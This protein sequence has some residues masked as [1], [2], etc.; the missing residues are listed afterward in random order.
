M[1][2]S[3]VCGVFVVSVSICSSF[4]H[5][6]SMKPLSSMNINV[7]N[8]NA[9]PAEVGFL[10][11]RCGVLFMTLGGYMLKNT[12]KSSDKETANALIKKGGNFDF[13]GIHLDTNKNGKSREAVMQQ[14]KA[15][16]DAYIAEM[17]DGKRLNNSIATPLISSDVD[18][19]NASYPYYKELDDLIH[20]SAKKKD[21]V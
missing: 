5:A 13:V 15:L 19:C 6:E 14:H 1:T 10:G 2:L 20:K 8:P 9:D 3:K 18:T 11:V 12:T 17:L 21:G 4:A 7:L 16:S